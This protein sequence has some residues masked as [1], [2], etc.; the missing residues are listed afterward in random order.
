MSNEWDPPI[1]EPPVLR[2][3][4]PRTNIKSIVIPDDM[5][6]EG[7]RL[8]AERQAAYEA[9]ITLVVKVEESGKGKGPAKDPVG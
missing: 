8:P 5:S 7:R 1:P 4:R 9:L 6:F 2:P 3:E